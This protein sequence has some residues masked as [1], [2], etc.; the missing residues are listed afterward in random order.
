MR[1]H[2]NI[3]IIAVFLGLLLISVGA[4]Y[5]PPAGAF[6]GVTIDLDQ[7]TFVEIDAGVMEVDLKESQLIVGEK[8]F[9]VTRFKIDDTLYETVLVD[10]RGRVTSL[11]SF[12]KG[13]RVVVKGVK[14]SNGDLI[15]GFVQKKGEGFREVV[16]PTFKRRA[17]SMTPIR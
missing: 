14:L 7:M 11:G 8:I 2:Y 1:I 5:P 3:R 17:R 9:S 4:G 6:S 15:A 10:A 13:E 12:K 16:D